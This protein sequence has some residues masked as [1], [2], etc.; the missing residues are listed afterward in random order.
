MDLELTLANK[1]ISP[2][3]AMALMKYM[4]DHLGF[5]EAL[6]ANLSPLRQTS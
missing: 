2:C 4:L 5:V 3:S 6:K 1:V